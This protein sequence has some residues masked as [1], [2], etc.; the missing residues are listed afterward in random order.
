MREVWLCKLRALWEQ[1]VVWLALLLAL[2]AVIC[3]I[4]LQRFY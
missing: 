3:G 2:F 1:P 4:V